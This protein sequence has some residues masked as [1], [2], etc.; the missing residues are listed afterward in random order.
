MWTGVGLEKAI[1][2]VTPDDKPIACTVRVE[3]RGLRFYPSIV[4]LGP[5]ALGSRAD[6]STCTDC[7]QLFHWPTP[8]QTCNKMDI[9]SL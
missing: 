4:G 3:G 9:F 1:A 2:S 8:Q 5:R 7:T 6:F